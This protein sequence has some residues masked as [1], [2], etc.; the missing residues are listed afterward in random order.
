MCRCSKDATNMTVLC[1]CSGC[2]CCIHSF[3]ELASLRHIRVSSQNFNQQICLADVFDAFAFGYCCIVLHHKIHTN[4]FQCFVFAI[5][6]LLQPFLKRTHNAEPKEH[7]GPT[8][9]STRF[10]KFTEPAAKFTTGISAPGIQVAIRCYCCKM[11][12][13]STCHLH[14]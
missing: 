3:M 6:R 8:K 14:Y 13:P 9:A 10:G 7:D 11:I 2:P 4:I 12:Q 5:C 1:D